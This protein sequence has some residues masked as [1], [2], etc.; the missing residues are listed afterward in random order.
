MIVPSYSQSGQAR[1]HAVIQRVLDY[2]PS[3][4]ERV[5]STGD[6]HQNEDSMVTEEVLDVPDWSQAP[7]AR[8]NEGWFKMIK[9]KT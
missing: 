9:Q 2:K 1:T 4:K 5:P 8:A 3:T 6:L 7:R